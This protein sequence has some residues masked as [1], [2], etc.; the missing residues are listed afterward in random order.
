MHAS[1]LWGDD[2]EVGVALVRPPV[3]VRRAIVGHPGEGVVPLAG[4]ADQGVDV[5]PVGEEA[6]QWKG[7]R[8]PGTQIPGVMTASTFI[9][10]GGRV[11]WDLHDADRAIAI[12]LR[13]DQYRELIVEVAD[14]TATID[15]INRI[16]QR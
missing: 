4:C 3:E 10:E 12:R 15:L 7:W 8:M 5:G 9:K 14:P 2:L 16:A 11:F 6:R 1:R 13:D